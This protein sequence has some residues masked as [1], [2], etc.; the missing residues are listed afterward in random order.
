MHLPMRTSGYLS[1]WCLYWNWLHTGPFATYQEKNTCPQEAYRLE[2]DR[3]EGRQFCCRIL[4]RPRLKD[5]KFSGTWHFRK[6][7]QRLCLCR[8]RGA[9][10]VHHRINKPRGNQDDWLWPCECPPPV[11]LFPDPAP[12]FEAMHLQGALGVRSPQPHLTENAYHGSQ[13]SCVFSCCLDFPVF[14]ESSWISSLNNKV[15]FGIWWNVWS[16]M[17]NWA[18]LSC[19][20]NTVSVI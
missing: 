19:W 20:Q 5:C 16:A 9:L 1:I 3:Q 14:H 10:G 7:L 17:F 13:D 11:L 12:A 4:P 8:D 2:E 18:E 6:S 15:L